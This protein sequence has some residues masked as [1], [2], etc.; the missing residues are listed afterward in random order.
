MGIENLFAKNMMDD[1]LQLKNQFA[2]ERE[3]VKASALQD[4]DF[5]ITYSKRMAN[6]NICFSVVVFLIAFKI[7]AKPVLKHLIYDEPFEI[8]GLGIVMLVLLGVLIFFVIVYCIVIW[9]KRVIHVRNSMVYCGK[10]S[11][12]YLEISKII[13][14]KVNVANVY[15]KGKKIFWI[16]AEFDNFESFLSWAEKCHIPVERK[17]DIVTKELSTDMNGNNIQIPTKYAILIVVIAFIGFFVMI[18]LM[19]MISM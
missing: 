7:F 6:M 1:A 3:T 15:S 16:S 18:P 8:D 11:W 13:V 2:E 14:N 19:V 9:T 12:N 4:I 17:V 5:L 10:K